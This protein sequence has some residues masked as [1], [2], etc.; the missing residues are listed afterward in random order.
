M[1]FLSEPLKR[2][3]PR[4]LIVVP[5]YNEA[6]RLDLAAFAGAIAAE[7][8]LEVIFVNDGSTDDT[9]GLL[10]AFVDSHG[11]QARVLHLAENQG[12]A[13]A[14]RQGLLRA[15]ESI[16]N[17]DT[18]KE[19]WV[20]YWDADLAA[21]LNQIHDLIDH[22]LQVGA[23]AVLGSR[24]RLLGRDIRRSRLRHFVGRVFAT[25]ASVYLGVRI[26][27]TQ[28][29]AK[30]FRAGASIRNAVVQ[31]FRSRWIFDV[32]LI[33]RLL[34]DGATIVEFPLHAWSA[35]ADSRLGASAYLLALRD[36]VRLV[37][38]RKP[39]RDKLSTGR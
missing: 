32:E 37:R 8:G 20:G 22:G 4:K 13:E 5:A 6:A 35:V 24:T 19:D 18:S 10:D 14:V 28:C 27:D 15:L 39:G 36:G 29:G 38:R 16:A 31:P 34:S 23:D 21:P 3:A 30:V 9:A 12:K 26:Y 17:D 1:E 11:P 7:P 33:E 2:V 25:V